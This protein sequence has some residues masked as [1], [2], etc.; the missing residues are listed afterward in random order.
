MP[1]PY[2]ENQRDPDNSYLRHAF[3]LIKALTTSTNW[4]NIHRLRVI[5][6]ILDSAWLIESA[7]HNES[8]RPFITAIHNLFKEEE[9]SKLIVYLSKSPSLIVLDPRIIAIHNGSYLIDPAV[10]L[11]SNISSRIDSTLGW[12]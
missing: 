3:D 10:T 1:I 2:P 7:I 6:D 9:M 5:T 12:V 4:S 11:Q 8:N